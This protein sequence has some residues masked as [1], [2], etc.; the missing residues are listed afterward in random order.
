MVEVREHF[1]VKFSV[2]P[3]G[4]SEEEVL[5]FVNGLMEKTGDGQSVA[6]R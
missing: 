4:L 6:D 5:G 2:V 1:G 3:Q